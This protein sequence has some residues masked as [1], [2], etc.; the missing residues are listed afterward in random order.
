V[1]L[2][3]LVVVCVMILVCCL[4]VVYSCDVVLSWVRSRC[5][6]VELDFVVMVCS[7]SLMNCEVG[8]LVLWVMFYVVFSIIECGIE[9]VN[10]FRCSM[11]VV[12]ECL[13]RWIF[14]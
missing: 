4:G 12:S 5:S 7:V 14:V 13:L 11:V 2:S 6:I 3:R 8:D 10:V 1:R 9:L